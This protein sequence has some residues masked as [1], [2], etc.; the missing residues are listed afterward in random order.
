MPMI[1]LIKS[2]TILNLFFFFLKFGWGIVDLQGCDNFCST[3]VIQLHLYTHPCSFRFFSHTDYH[4]IRG[5]VPFA[6]QQI[7]IGQSFRIPQCVYASHKPPVHPFPPVCSY[8]EVIEFHES[9]LYFNAV[10]PNLNLTQAQDSMRHI[11]LKA[12]F[13]PGLEMS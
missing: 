7:P 6:I 1:N 10:A 3:T 13:S 8:I 4:R 11:K 12:V 9:Q 5:S 2:F